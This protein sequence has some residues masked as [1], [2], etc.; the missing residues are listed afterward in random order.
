MQKI[1]AI[2]YSIP[3]IGLSVVVGFGVSA[4]T[5]LHWSSASIFTGC[6]LIL[7][8][9]WLFEDDAR[10]EVDNIRNDVNRNNSINY[11]LVLVLCILGIWIQIRI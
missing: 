2:L 5:K 8:G 1:Q 9:T 3:L 6:V 7:L 4:Y 11:F 10:T